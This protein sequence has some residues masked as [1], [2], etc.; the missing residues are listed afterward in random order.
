MNYM[1][2]RVVYSVCA[3]V[4]VLLTTFTLVVANNDFVEVDLKHDTSEIS[5]AM[6][7]RVWL[8]ATNIPNNW[9]PTFSTVWLSVNLSNQPDTT[10][11]G[12]FTQVG[13]IAD[14]NGLS[15]FVYAEP[16]AF[17][18]N[19][20]ECLQGNPYLYNN[21]VHKY[22]GCKGNVGQYVSLNTQHLVELVTYNDGYWYAR[23]QDANGVPHDVARIP[24][25]TVLV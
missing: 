5:T 14:S 15:W 9:Y 18:A 4:L 22:L 24:C 12:L 19:G 2:R 1:G 10:F 16:Y 13:L 3:T 21:D 17:S 20:A 7:Y 25:K 23:I 6:D 8:K 11:G